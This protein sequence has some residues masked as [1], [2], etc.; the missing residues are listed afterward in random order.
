L[1]F[2]CLKSLS[3][4]EEM[5]GVSTKFR[6]KKMKKILAFLGIFAIALPL[7]AEEEAV[8]NQSSFW[9]T[10]IMIAIAI[11]FFYFILWRPEQRRRKDME[12]KRGAMKKG[13]RITAMGIVGT[14]DRIKEQTVIVKMV[15]G[16]K[17]EFVKGAISEVKPKEEVSAEEEKETQETG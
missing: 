10:L 17:I 9:Q 15:D 4:R 14:I 1:H 16:S 2:A 8:R 5:P 7:M 12:K 13:D 3:K 6:G 11:L